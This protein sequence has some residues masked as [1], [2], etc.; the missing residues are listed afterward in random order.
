MRHVGVDGCK[1]GWL[2]VTRSGAALEYRVFSNINQLAEAFSAADRVLIDIPIGLP[3]G[4]VPVR[5][6]DRMARQLLGR[7]RRSSVFPVPCREALAASD[8]EQAQKIN[9]EHLGRS[10]NEQTRGISQKIA[11]VDRFFLDRR[12]KHAIIREVH[13]E[14]CF[15]ALDRRRSMA[16]KKSTAEGI[17]E[18]LRVL[19]RYD[20]GI[21][22][23]LSKTLEETFREAVKADDLLDA[24][25]SFVTSE[26]RDGDLVSLTGEPSRDLAGLP[27]EMVYLKT[28]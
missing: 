6:C 4:D 5:P 28:W 15:W 20:R 24:A 9:R 27:M 14:L 26:A 7:P 22:L 17:Q 8:L 10:I 1:A 25:V 16:H 18:R 19:S 12:L 13:P 21:S 23:L 3:W 2:A 11:E